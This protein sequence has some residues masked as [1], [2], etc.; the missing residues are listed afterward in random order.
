MFVKKSLDVHTATTI[1]VTNQCGERKSEQGSLRDVHLNTTTN[2]IFKISLFVHMLC[3]T[4]I[5][6]VN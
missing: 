1:H 4:A 3:L 6:I 5:I 2:I